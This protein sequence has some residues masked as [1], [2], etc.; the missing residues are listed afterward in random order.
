LQTVTPT[1][2]SSPVPAGLARPR[3]AALLRAAVVLF[4]ALLPGSAGIARAGQAARTLLNVSYD[5]TRELY[6]QINA[7]FQA[8][9]LKKTGQAVT[10]EMS[11]GGSAAQA[12][13]VIAGLPAD[14]VT[15]GV[16]S[17]IDALHDQGG[18]L[19]ENW[20]SRLPNDST[21]Y[22]SVVVFLVRRGNPKHIVDWG[23]L[24]RPG[25]TVVTPNPKTSAGGR[26]NFLAAYA[27]AQRHSAGNP[28][29]ARAYMKALYQHVTVLNP[30]A[31][32]TTLAFT[33]QQLGDVLLAWENEAFLSIKE[34]GP[35][36]FQIVVPSISILAE[37]PVAVVDR[38]AQR[39]GTERL[40]QAYLR[41][42][43]TPEAQEIIAENFYRP[44]DPAVAARHA[45]QF[46]H[47]TLVN[48]SAFGGWRKAQAKFFDDGGLFDQLY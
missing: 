1:R 46:P 18:L 44:I 2:G 30:A 17:D 27:Y 16:A 12:R 36:K 43:Y 11:H 38:N 20:Q 45:A 7:H 40:A 34:A 15:L 29:A 39:H 5:P 4:A 24:V 28:A 33:Q 42:L 9:W 22:T 48:I 8:Y 41:F 13:S 23:D 47:V 26:W 31:R 19:P 14:V 3:V 37:P 35:G 10:V 6:D 32:A 21:P 25:I